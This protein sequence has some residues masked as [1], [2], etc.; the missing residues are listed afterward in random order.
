MLKVI[1]LMIGVLF[2][3]VMIW[4]TSAFDLKSSMNISAGLFSAGLIVFYSIILIVS[5]LGVLISVLQESYVARLYAMATYFTVAG[6]L[7]SYFLRKYDLDFPF[8]GLTAS[9]TLSILTGIPAI[10]CLGVAF[11]FSLKRRGDI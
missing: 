4:A 8:Y 7:G 11:Y 3:G 10:A 6:F 1:G 9:G 2:F 5:L